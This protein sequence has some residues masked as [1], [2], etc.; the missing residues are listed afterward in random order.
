ML[1]TSA[2]KVYWD[3][4]SRNQMTVDPIRKAAER[5]FCFQR[6][7]SATAVVKIA[8][9]KCQKWK[10]HNDWE[11][12]SKEMAVPKEQWRH[13]HKFS[14]ITWLQTSIIKATK[15]SPCPPPRS[16]W[17]DLSRLKRRCGADRCLSEGA[18]EEA[19]SFD[20]LS[21]ALCKA[22]AATSA[23]SVFSD[24][25]LCTQLQW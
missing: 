21:T 19:G 18:D 14:C 16:W 4:S 1:E 3:F 23:T 13:T 24:M 2:T 17:T 25:V 20:A 8:I 6:S 11:T 22:S 5:C 10:D 12:G 7:T 15:I 9:Q